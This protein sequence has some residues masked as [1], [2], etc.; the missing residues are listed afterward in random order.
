MKKTAF[1]I[2]YITLLL[3][4]VGETQA[5]STLVKGRVIKKSNGEAVESA[6]VTVKGTSNATVT[7][8][9]GMFSIN[10][11]NKTATLV[12]SFLGLKNAEKQVNAGSTVE[13][14]LDEEAAASLNEV[15]VVG[16]GTQKVTKV[17]G[18]IA[19]VKGADIEKLRPVRTEEA[20]QGR[21]AGVNVIQNG[22]PGAKPTVLVR[23]IPS[24]SGTDPVV[25]IDGVPQTLTDLNSINASD[26]ESINV[27]KDAATSAIYGVKGGNGVIL[28]TTKNGRKNQKTE[29]NVSSNYGI[30]QVLNTVGVLNATEYAAIINEGSL[31]S[32]G[33]V[34]FPD[35]SVL[36]VGTN[37]QNEVFKDAALQSHNVTARGG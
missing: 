24:F 3:V 33:G 10:I 13:I 12:V 34:I 22:S 30:Q 9:D 1:Y 35:L 7:N 6:S 25:I 20:L 4:F 31:T 36:G 2:L 32:G 28:V 8:K 5:Q 17:S 18:S 23:G 16:Y 27:L 15:V 14:A 26:I 29:F 11:Q 21:A 37:W 19:T